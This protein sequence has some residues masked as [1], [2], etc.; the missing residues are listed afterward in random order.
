ME[1]VDDGGTALDEAGTRPI[2]SSI[3]PQVESYHLSLNLVVSESERWG[4]GVCSFILDYGAVRRRERV[5]RLWVA[6]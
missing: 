3:F 4:R 1:L 6:G 2:W 5:A